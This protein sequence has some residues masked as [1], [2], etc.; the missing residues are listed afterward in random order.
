VGGE[1]RFWCRLRSRF[2]DQKGHSVSLAGLIYSP[3]ALFSSIA[4]ITA[5]YRPQKPWISYRAIN[6]L[7]RL[8]SPTWNVLEFGAGMSTAWLAS[9]CALV[10][11][12][13]SNKMWYDAVSHMLTR[14]HISNV[15]LRLANSDD[16]HILAGIGDGFFDFA[17]V[18]GI[19]RDKCMRTALSK[20]KRGGYVFLDNSD[21]FVGNPQGHTR[22]AEN[23][24][25]SYLKQSGGEA[26]YFVDFSPA[27]FSVSEGLL[28]RV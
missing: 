7:D 15:D 5:G 28:A 19:N 25:V 23:L 1:R 3:C 16:Y 9:R 11:S 20:V 8:L 6:Y 13:E 12:I 2:R 17:L 27:T 4:R 26:R 18:D 24:L 21:Q 14:Q 10:I 22:L